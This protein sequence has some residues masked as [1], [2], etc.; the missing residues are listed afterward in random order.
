MP[1]DDDSLMLHGTTLYTTCSALRL[2]CIDTYLLHA[3]DDYLNK[4]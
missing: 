2:R 1:D 4:N 3:W